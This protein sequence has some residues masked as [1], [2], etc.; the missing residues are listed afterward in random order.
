MK[1]AFNGLMSRNSHLYRRI[2][3]ELENMLI[4]IF[5]TEMQRE[6]NKENDGREYSRSVRQLQEV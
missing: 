6:K 2:I 1:N 4:E 5:I 3:S